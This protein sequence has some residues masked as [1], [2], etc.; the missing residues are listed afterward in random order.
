MPLSHQAALPSLPSCQ[1][2]IPIAIQEKST[3]I[4]YWRWGPAGIRTTVIH[5]VSTTQPPLA[6]RTS[7]E[8][9]GDFTQRCSSSSR[10]L[11]TDGRAIAAGAGIGAPRRVPSAP[12]QAPLRVCALERRQSWQA[13]AAEHAE[14]APRWARPCKVFRLACCVTP[15]TSSPLQLLVQRRPRG[16]AEPW[17]V[18][19]CA[20]A[21]AF[22]RA[23][24]RQRPQLPCH[25]ESRTFFYTF[26]ALCRARVALLTRNCLLAGRWW[27][28]HYAAQVVEP[29][30]P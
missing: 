28:H 1:V 21:S 2:P 19:Q 14:R 4:G 27:P 24:L 23:S 22:A 10:E 11:T 20:F 29:G 6:G 3:L 30:Q 7:G 18:P 12:E 16:G 8:G 13:G 17:Y 25:S 9:R 15:T 26:G 5:R